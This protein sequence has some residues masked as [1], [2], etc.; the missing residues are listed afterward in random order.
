MGVEHRIE[1][2]QV[3]TGKLV[4]GLTRMDLL[5]VQSAEL[6]VVQKDQVV[7]LEVEIALVEVTTSHP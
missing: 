7:E 3:A 5:R 1:V 2:D 6:A 4:V